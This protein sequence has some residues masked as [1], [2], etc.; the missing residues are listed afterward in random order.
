[1]KYSIPIFGNVN[2]SAY[3]SQH[4]LG[5]FPSQKRG[6]F[7]DHSGHNS[8]LLWQISACQ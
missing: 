3:G 5:C 4:E 6:C 7:L 1:M 8:E 2:S